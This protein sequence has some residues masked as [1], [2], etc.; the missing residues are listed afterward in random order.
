MH[1]KHGLNR[2]ALEQAVVDHGLGTG[3]TFFAG[4]KNQHGGAVEVA[5]LGQ[6]T[7][8]AHQ[9]RGMAV[10]AAAVHQAGLFR[11]PG[12]VVVLGHGQRVHVGAQ[13]DHPAAAVALALDHGHQAGLADAGMDGVHTAD[14]ERLLHAMGGVD[15]FKAQ[16]RVRVQVAPQGGQLGVESGDVG[17]GA[18]VGWCISRDCPF[19]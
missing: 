13:P 9:H 18:A 12:K 8:R 1:A 10:V 2:K 11:L 3:I 16:F 19:R 6:V 17:K 14:F 7:R 15:L 4:L 5:R